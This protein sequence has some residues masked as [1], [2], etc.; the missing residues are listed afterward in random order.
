MNKILKKYNQKID[1][2]SYM[3]KQKFIASQSQVQMKKHLKTSRNHNLHFLSNSN[4]SSISVTK[5]IANPMSLPQ[6]PTAFSIP[7]VIKRNTN[8]HTNILLNSPSDSRQYLHSNASRP[9][10]IVSAS[11]APSSHHRYP[12]STKNSQTLVGM[13]D[14]LNKQMQTL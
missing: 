5:S 10:A 11:C 1:Q 8:N 4:E 6:S 2:I 14:Y 12:R 7:T 13:K 9:T 3:E